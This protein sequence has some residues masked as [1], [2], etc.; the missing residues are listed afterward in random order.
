MA[1]Y[2]TKKFNNVFYKTVKI[3]T[4]NF[5]IIAVDTIEIKTVLAPQNDNSSRGFVK[6][7]KGDGQKMTRNG[8]KMNS[9]IVAT[10]L[11]ESVF[12]KE[13]DLNKD[14]GTCLS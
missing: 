3:Q 14:C 1:I 13:T 10:R 12:S 11:G 5:Y 9:T 7:D 2:E 6:N 4:R 8:R